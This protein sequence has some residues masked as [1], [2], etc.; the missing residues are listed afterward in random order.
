MHSSEVSIAAAP[1]P[2]RRRGRP[3]SQTRKDTMN[4]TLR[5]LRPFYGDLKDLA[6][7]LGVP[8]GQAVMI[9]VEFYV[10]SRSASGSAQ[11]HPSLQ[12]L[13]AANDR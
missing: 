8:P 2:Q 10:Q 7:K 4:V 1:A 3:R 9:A 12:V 5:L 13:A 6:K 11:S